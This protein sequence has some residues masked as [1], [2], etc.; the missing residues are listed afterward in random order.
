MG[1]QVLQ[2]VS[3]LA[4]ATQAFVNRLFASLQRFQT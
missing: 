2:D 4:N 1:W 3:Q